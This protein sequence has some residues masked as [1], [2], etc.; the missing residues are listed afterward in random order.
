VIFDHAI[1]LLGLCS[2][3]TKRKNAMVCIISDYVVQTQGAL[4]DLCIEVNN[5]IVK[6]VEN[7]AKV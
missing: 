1:L 5:P 4:I 7:K 3:P 2:L 6:N